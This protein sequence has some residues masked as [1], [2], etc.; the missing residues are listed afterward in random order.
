MKYYFIV[1]PN[2]GNGSGMNVWNK[3]EKL[4]IQKHVDYSIYFTTG[5]LDAMNKAA[6]IT[7]DLKEET[8]V[9]VVG[10]DGTIDEVLNGL[11]LDAPVIFG[12]IPSGSGN[13]L[14]RSLGMNDGVE[15]A[16]RK[17]IDEPYV[18][19]MDFGVL[20]LPYGKERRF[21]VSCG[22][23][24]D[25][26]VCHSIEQ[27]TLKNFFN[28]VNMGKAVYTAIGFGEFLK[29]KATKGYVIIDGGEKTA[30]DEVFFMSFQNHPYEGGGYLFAPNAKW[31]DGKIDVTV[32]ST[33]D[34]TKLFP[35]LIDK[36]SGLREND[37]VSF[38]TCNEVK[39][40]LDKPLAVHADGENM[41]RQTDFSVKCIHD[42]LKVFA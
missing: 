29:A 20:E 31:D 19:G 10:G 6:E 34:K 38:Y 12:F 7:S 2:S 15:S 23:G 1:N 18:I 27:S 33:V 37:F 5:H 17:I 14:G 16:V 26:A 13:D 9:V 11:N 32:V 8:A 30:F 28:K 39:V 25:A 22:I 36:K 21:A 3:A 41:G 35:I 4:L 24:F 40:H 42:R